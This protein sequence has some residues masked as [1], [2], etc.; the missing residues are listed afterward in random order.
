MLIRDSQVKTR[1]IIRC[2]ALSLLYH[3]FT[4]C[5]AW[6]GRLTKSIEINH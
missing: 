4:C 6:N 5:L 3:Q 1:N 2:F